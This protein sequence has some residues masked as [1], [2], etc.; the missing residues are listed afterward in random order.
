MDIQTFALYVTLA[1]DS[2][3]RGLRLTLNAPISVNFP[4]KDLHLTW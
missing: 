3:M 1:L 4:G 2:Q